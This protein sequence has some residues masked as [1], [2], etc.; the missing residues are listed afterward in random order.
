MARDHRQLGINHNDLLHTNHLSNGL[1][2]QLR[3]AIFN[4]LDSIERKFARSSDRPIADQLNG[5]R[6]NRFQGTRLSEV[7][8]G[9]IGNDII[10]GQGG[11]DFIFARDGDDRVQGGA[12]KDFLFGGLGNDIL[13][14]GRGSDRISGGLGDDVIFGKRGNDVVTYVAGDG[15]D[16]VSGGAG[17]DRIKIIGDLTQNNNFTLGKTEGTK[18]L[19]QQI[20][21]E[22]Q[23]NSAANFTLTVD[24]TEVFDVQGG[25]G[26]DILQVSNLADTGVKRIKFRGGEGDDI[27]DASASG[28]RVTA[29]GGK[30]NDTLTGG[31]LADILV[32][33]DGV[34]TLTGGEGRDRFVYGGNPFGNGTPVVNAATGIGVLNQPDKITDYTIGEDV[35]ALS[36]KA[37]GIKDIQFTEGTASSIGNG[38]IINLTDG[39]ANAAAAAKAIADN[40]AVTA[41]EGA[42]LYFNTT[43]GIS[44][45][46]YSSNLAEGGDISVLANLSNQTVAGNQANFGAN[47]FML[48]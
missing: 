26:N 7:I 32:G 43:L 21:L 40:D 9:S 34:D 24:T 46:A 45:L 4:E 6:S 35:F 15:N 11:S 16:T 44:R 2:G 18:A 8:V 38:N 19:F 10:N 27:L 48:V 36:S 17:F 12:G 14:G 39:F 28:V 23:P 47:D 13:K 3:N 25:G 5:N 31:A 1:V 20:G 22:N 29:R 33:G 41:K 37:L 30:G 42:F